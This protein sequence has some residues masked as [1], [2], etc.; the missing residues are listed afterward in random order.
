MLLFQT[1][2]RCDLDSTLQIITK[3]AVTQSETLENV[4]MCVNV[5]FVRLFSI[6]HFILHAKRHLDLHNFLVHIFIIVAK[7]SSMFTPLRI[8]EKAYTFKSFYVYIRGGLQNNF[9][10]VKE[11]S[12]TCAGDYTYPKSE[13]QVN[14]I[15]ILR[16]FVL[17]VLFLWN[18]LSD[19]LFCVEYLSRLGCNA[20]STGKYFY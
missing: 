17:M 7:S 12:A 8:S 2:L 4:N 14:G 3:N 5:M 6:R 15:Q 9:D 11:D 10:F 1:R 20:M 16:T 13:V 18:A 19:E